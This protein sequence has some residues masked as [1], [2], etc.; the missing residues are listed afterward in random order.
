VHRQRRGG[1]G[2]R[3]YF[4]DIQAFIRSV[5]APKYPFMRSTRRWR[6]GRGVFAANCAGCHGTY[7]E[8]EADETY[9][10]LLFPLDLIGTDPVV[11]EG[12]TKYA[13]ELVDWYN[14]SFYGSV[15]RMEPDD[16]FPGYMAPPLDGVWATGPFLHNGSVPTIELV[17]DSTQAAD[18]LAARRLS[19][20]RT[21]TRAGSAGRSS[22]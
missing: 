4:A 3:R 1:A 16:P 9:P 19:T 12:G 14:E 15:T 20:A 21:S 11:A 18:L 13:P 10:N 6:R 22:S 2:D 5:R 17:L 7:A 8:D